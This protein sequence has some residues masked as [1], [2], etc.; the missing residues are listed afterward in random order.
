MAD[1]D[2]LL[3]IVR[4]FF[5]D[6]EWVLS[7]IEGQTVLSGG[8]RGDNGSWRCFA[9]VDEDARWFAFYSMVDTNA[10]ADSRPALA[11]FL[12][13]ANYGLILG[14]FEMDFA[15]GEIR[16]K[17]AIDVTGDRLTSDLMR[18]MVYANV[19]TMDR[20][21]QG[22]MRVAYGGASPTEAIQTIEGG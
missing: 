22:I 7:Q 21:V 13:R 3:E 12:T 11:E 18:P 14:N 2:S 5:V 9:Q 15:D 10:P 4:Q 6:E 16:Y 8:F 1:S 19:V 17:T 20:Y